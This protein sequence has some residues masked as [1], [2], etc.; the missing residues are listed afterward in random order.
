MYEVLKTMTQA[1]RIEYIAR[2]LV[3][4]LSV[5]G[6]SGEVAIANRVEMILRSFPYF[7]KF[8]EQLWTKGLKNDALERKNIFAFIKKENQSKT[9]IFHSH[10][11]T[12]GI[13]DYG[14]IQ[15]LA[16]DSDA[17]TNYFASYTED[18]DVQADAQSGDYLFGRG[19]LD[20]K[21]GIAVNI[22]NILYFSEH[23]EQLSGNILL[24][25]N[26]VEENDHTGAIE[27]TQVIADMK[28]D[29]Y[30]FLA[31]INTDFVS[32]LYQ[33]DTTR[34]IYT[35]AA[36]KILSCFY[37]KGRET[38]VGSTLQGIDPTLLSSAINLAIN[39]NLDLCETIPD[40]EI[41]P[42]SAL[43]QRDQKDFYNVQTAKIAHLY[44]NTFL[45]EKSASDI[46][47]RFAEVAKAAIEEV[48]ANYKLRLARYQN[49]IGIS[50]V[51][52]F[53]VQFYTFDDYCQMLVDKGN[54][55]LALIDT[56]KNEHSALDRRE[57]G[58]QLID[59]LEKATG[60]DSPKVVLFIAPPFCPHNFINQDSRVDTVLDQTLAEFSSTETFK[61][62]RFFPYL[63]DSSYLSMR[64]SKVE[65]DRLLNNF[66]LSD[67]IYPL[68]FETIRSLDIPA[69]DLGVYG[70][71][72]HTWKERLYKPYSYQTLPKIIQSFTRKLLASDD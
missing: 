50:T 13:E 3:S 35:G 31:A 12:V 59:Y 25:V 54:D 36:G 4:I 60:E 39:T 46:L 68:P 19:M 48:A 44:F 45:Y 65:I 53:E 61:K 2:D 51:A 66:P 28:S 5:N 23:L 27:A 63:S 43:Y 7:Q 57:A 64:E 1:E 70:K 32:P 67:V 10:M 29:G 14:T 42:S 18:I 71:G 49:S 17:L 40:E 20:M 37:I 8:P 47:M 30:E 72:A 55:V 15:D 34:Y 38:H 24:M 33:G 16:G 9:V 62:R 11:D 52:D 69:I 22:S 21:S 56:F 58:F 6:T 41:L 26:P